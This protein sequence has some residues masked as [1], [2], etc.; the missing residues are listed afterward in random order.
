MEKREQTD[1]Y[2][3]VHHDKET[4]EI[5][6]LDYIF[7]HSDGFKG[8][9]GTRFEPVSKEQYKEETSKA[10]IIER[11]EDCGIVTCDNEQAKKAAL[12]SLYKQMKAN[13][14]IEYFCFD[15]SYIEHWDKLRA[16]GYPENKYPVFNCTGGGRCF[17]KNF[18]G[19]INP[20]LSKLIREI[21]S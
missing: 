20:E 8:A 11:L 4:G 19:N 2:Q 10:R 16:L 18:E 17:D 12:N 9:T 7:R 6:M 15:L 1:Y 5:I 13:D 3:V 21:E 14:E